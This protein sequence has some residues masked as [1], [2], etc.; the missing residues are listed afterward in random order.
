MTDG[1][2]KAPSGSRIIETVL[3]T[4]I[5]A[6]LFFAPYS[7]AEEPGRSPVTFVRRAKSS[8]G[9]RHICPRSKRPEAPPR[10]ARDRFSRRA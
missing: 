5:L 10:R 2:R 8:A 9:S 1:P 3:A 6:C 7:G 4:L